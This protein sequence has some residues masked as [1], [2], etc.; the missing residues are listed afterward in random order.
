M[1]G[2]VAYVVLFVFSLVFYKERT[3]FLD[4]AFN[5]FHI[6]KGQGFAIQ[7]YRFG[8]II[9]QILPLLA[10]KAGLPLNLIL[11]LYSS[12]FIL[13]YFTGYFIC[14]SV[15]KRYDFALLILLF[16]ILF[17]ADSF[18]WMVSQLPQAVIMLLVLFALISQK[19]L[20]MVTPLTWGIILL[21]LITVIFYHPLIVFVILF[22]I[23]FF[24]LSKNSFF[25]RKLLYCITLIYFVGLLIKMF[26]FKTPYE[27]HSMSGMKNFIS[28]FPN[29]FTTYSNKR[30][31][32]NCLEL[33]YWVII[34][35]VGIVIFYFKNSDFRKLC[36]FIIS[37]TGYLFLVNISYPT[38]ITP[39]FYIENLYLPLGIFLGLP[40]IFD[41]LPVLD[42]KKLAMPLLVLILITGC[43]RIYFTHNTYT[44]RLDWQRAY[45][46]Q[47]GDKKIIASSK[48]A[49]AGILMMLWGT[50]Y[51]FWLL[52]TL[53]Q[54]K[55]AS[56]II[57]D[58]PGDRV[59]ARGV[60]NKFL[61]NWDIF[62][63]K[64]LPAKYFR[65]E[66]TTTGYIVEPN[67]L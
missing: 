55:S 50:P 56:I 30:F 12:S 57:D 34:C 35:T 28:L 23:V 26:L 65:F 27:V 48:K 60:T 13:Y 31:L 15:L 45:L 62:T 24:I 42:K 59:W 58:R 5:V 2:I 63:Y 16:N 1:T 44:A 52:S 67:T 43:A 32:L 11:E 54:G 66:D 39:N 3:V 51:E 21:I 61:V 20:K 40:V 29:Y 6:I 17:V 22:S 64:E 8:D 37:F 7:I 9:N 46:K 4:M 25:D 49:N 33:Y 14:G 53:E 36:F 10:C 18:Y 47:N 41:M 19:E 38:P